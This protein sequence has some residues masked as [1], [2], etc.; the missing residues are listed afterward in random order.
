[1]D[2]QSLGLFDIILTSQGKEVDIQIHCPDKVVPFTRQIEEGISQ[3]LVRNDLTPARVLV[4]RMERPVTLT[5]VFPKIYEGKNSIN[6]K[7]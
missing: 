5:E 3:I 4:R 7:V 1:M 2:V 6:V